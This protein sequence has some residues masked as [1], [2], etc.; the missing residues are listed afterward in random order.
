MGIE[1]EMWRTLKIKIIHNYV[2]THRRDVYSGRFKTVTNTMC[3]NARK[4]Y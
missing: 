2:H 4:Q 3:V 1:V